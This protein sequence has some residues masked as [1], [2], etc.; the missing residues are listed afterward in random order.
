MSQRTVEVVG[1][2]GQH[3]S[4]PRPAI[5][6][7]RREARHEQF[8]YGG[9]HRLDEELLELVDH[10]QQ[11]RRDA[12]QDPFDVLRTGWRTVDRALV[13]APESGNVLRHWAEHLQT[14]GVP[15][16]GCTPEAIGLCADKRRLAA[17]LGARRIDTVPT[18]SV[19]NPR[20]YADIKA[21]LLAEV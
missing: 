15:S 9:V 14:A 19:D 17:F 1:P 8:P 20:D 3:E 11:L 10:Q 13:I 21:K 2:Q 4:D 6:G 18:W 12:G 7:D 16:L 5:G